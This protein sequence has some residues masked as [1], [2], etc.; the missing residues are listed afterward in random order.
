[1]SLDF[2]PVEIDFAEIRHESW[3]TGGSF[4]AFDKASHAPL[5]PHKLDHTLAFM[6]ESRWVIR[7]TKFALETSALQDD[8]D[9]CWSG[10]P[11]ARLP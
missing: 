7:P 11:K 3:E 10:F 8:Y 4:S 6:F 9:A 5:A 1:M 2:T